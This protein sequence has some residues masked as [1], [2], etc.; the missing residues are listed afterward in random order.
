MPTILSDLLHKSHSASLCSTST[1]V[2]LVI[3]ALT[4]IIPLVGV[5]L[6]HNYWQET[7][8]FYE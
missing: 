6:T 3:G 7:D 8:T 5:V 4:L 1:L 2:T